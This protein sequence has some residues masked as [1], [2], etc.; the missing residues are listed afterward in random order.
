MKTRWLSSVVFI[1]FLGSGLSSAW[2]DDDDH[3]QFPKNATFTTLITTP[4]QIEGLTGDNHRNLYTGYGR[5]GRASVSHLANQSKQA[6][7][8]SGGLC[9]A[10]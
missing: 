3:R 2:A 4:R 10:G 6:C 8:N 1:F 9:C 7:P 5:L